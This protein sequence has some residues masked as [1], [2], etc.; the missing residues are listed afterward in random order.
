VA[1]VNVALTET[2]V[3]ATPTG[4]PDIEATVAARLES[5]P[6]PTPDPNLIPESDLEAS[7]GLV[8]FVGGI[9]NAVFSILRWLWNL[10]A[11]G[12]VGLQLCCCLIIPIGALIALARESL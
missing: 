8:A 6:A 3:I 12:G 2:A 11:F 7:G 5:S 4:L 1:A 9:I 10:F